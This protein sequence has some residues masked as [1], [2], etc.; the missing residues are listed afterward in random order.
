MQKIWT[1]TNAAVHMPFLEG[2]FRVEVKKILQSYPN[3]FKRGISAFPIFVQEFLHAGILCFIFGW[4]FFLFF[5]FLFLHQYTHANKLCSGFGTS[6]TFS[7]VLR[8]N[9]V[10]VSGTKSGSLLV[11]EQQHM[12]HT[13]V[14]L[15]SPV[16]L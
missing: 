2:V 4:G 10:C 15:P 16:S 9:H 3:S 6:A 11:P 8:C 13:N 7:D 14:I 1:N 5:F 12:H